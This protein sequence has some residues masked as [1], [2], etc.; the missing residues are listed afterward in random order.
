MKFLPTISLLV[1]SLLKLTQAHINT[2]QGSDYREHRGP[3]AAGSL[4]VAKRPRYEHRLISAESGLAG[5]ALKYRAN[6]SAQANLDAASPEHSDFPARKDPRSTM[7]ISLNIGDPAEGFSTT[8][9][10]AVAKGSMVI[11]RAAAAP[12]CDTVAFAHRG[13]T[14]RILQCCGSWR[15]GSAG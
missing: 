9:G 5:F 13:A 15:Y 8:G 10:D 1:C 2:E 6:D 11:G 4:R 14:G 12:A 3:A 7:A